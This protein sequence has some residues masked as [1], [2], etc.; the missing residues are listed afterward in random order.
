MGDAVSA[1][2]APG[3]QASAS[4][5]AGDVPQTKPLGLWADSWRRL[6]RN[7]VAIIGLV[8]ISIFLVIGAARD[9]SWDHM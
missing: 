3:S 8:I 4:L 6:K 2:S 7:K 1:P 9:H 5:P